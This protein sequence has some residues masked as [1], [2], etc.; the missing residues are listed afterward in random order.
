MTQS[1]PGKTPVLAVLTWL[2][3][4]LA[5]AA[6]LALAY[7]LGE[8][9][10]AEDR[11]A[12]LFRASVGLFVLSRLFMFVPLSGSGTR[13]RRWWVDYVLIVAAVIWWLADRRSE[14]LILRIGAIYSVIL[15]AGALCQAVAGAL[16]GGLDRPY[17]G[18]GVRRLLA[19]AV[20]LVLLGGA[21][22]MLPI[23]WQGAYPV[24]TDHPLVK[25]QFGMHA[26]ECVFTATAA[27]TGTGLAV[28]DVGYQFSRVGQV[29]LLVLMQVGGLAILVIGSVLGWRF[30]HAIGWGGTQEDEISPT[31]V[32][33]LIRFV[34]GIAFLIEAVGTV[35]LFVVRESA[36]TTTQAASSFWHWFDSAFLS[37]SAFCNVGLTLSQGSLIAHGRDYALYGTI[38]PLMVLGTLGGPVL[39]DL[40]RRRVPGQASSKESRVMW[41]VTL[42]LVVLGAAALYATE[43]SRYWQLRYPR[44]KTAGRIMLPVDASQP[45]P[46]QAASSRAITFSDENAARVDSQRLWTMEPRQRAAASLFHGIASRTG[47]MQVAR[48]DEASLSPSGRAALTFLMLIG[49]GLGGTAGGLRIVIVWLLIGSV[50]LRPATSEKLGPS[51]RSA[52]SHRAVATAAAI[53]AAMFVLIFLVAFVLIYREAGSVE[54]CL[55][56]AVSA[57]CNVGLSTGLTQQLSVQGQIAVIVG[58]LVGRVIPLAILLPYLVTFAG[59]S[60]RQQRN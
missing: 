32:R 26:L 43:S 57:C 31:R 11:V 15:G 51:R 49:G 9:E 24:Q 53:A 8:L 36:A 30:R 23:C 54:A 6:A 4:A 33:R 20:V 19:G 18:R 7:G 47:G 48:L 29:V 59:S 35:V 5:G 38:L 45:S 40:F 46:T 44:E 52:Q 2:L 37:V 28:C 42:L 60:N 1:I 41:S 55:F 56:E 3:S 21:V 22:L 10:V 58:M 12:V 27:L 16:A 25:Y 50:F 14:Y 39:Y 34:V 13:L 17:V